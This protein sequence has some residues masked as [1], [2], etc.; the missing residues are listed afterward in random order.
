MVKPQ[1]SSIIQSTPLVLDTEELPVIWVQEINLDRTQEFIKELIKL[2]SDPEVEAIF[3]YIS[4]YGG[5]VFAILAMVEAMLN[6]NKPIH[7]VGLGLCASGGGILLAAAPG[8]RYITENSFMHI[9]HIQTG[10][11]GDLPGIENDVVQTKKIEDKIFSI[12]TKRANISVKELK[13]RLVDNRR[14]WQLSA[15]QAK[16]FGFVDVIGMPNLKKT[17]VTEVEW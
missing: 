2:D 12:I 10:M 16:K 8:M 4:S 7:T 5:D 14:E 17:L 3:I 6:C 15:T 9:H 13:A 11:N 1:T